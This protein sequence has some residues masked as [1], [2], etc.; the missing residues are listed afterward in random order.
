M[1]GPCDC[2]C[3]LD[4]DFFVVGL[5]IVIVLMR[6]RGRSSHLQEYSLLD[7]SAHDE[8]AWLIEYESL[9]IYNP[10][11]GKGMKKER[12]RRRRKNLTQTTK[13]AYSV[14]NRAVLKGTVVAV[15]TYVGQ[16]YYGDL[17]GLKIS[18][19]FL[20]FPLLTNR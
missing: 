2:A 13:G 19:G 18:F 16:D 17:K 9:T 12:R 4:D 14:V 20:F 5:T 1:D 8:D 11:I 6:R 3:G 15:K 7:V 10:P